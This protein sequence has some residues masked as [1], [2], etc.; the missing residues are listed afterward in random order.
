MLAL[1]VV[2]A[3]VDVLPSSPDL[4]SEDWRGSGR[5]TVHMGRKQTLEDRKR[6]WDD[7][8]VP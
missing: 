8:L 6:P 4:V 3:G 1:A 7:I 2:S 5:E